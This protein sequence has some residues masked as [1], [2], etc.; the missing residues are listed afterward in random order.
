MSSDDIKSSIRT[1]HQRLED[2][3]PLDSETRE[4]LAQLDAD[5]HRLL[6]AKADVRIEEDG[7]QERLE[8]IAAD[9][10]SR[11]PQLSAILRELGDA[12]ARVGI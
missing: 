3:G 7:L 6:A 1:L 12:L 5:L 4:L 8:S 9:F 10:D 2:A 11:H